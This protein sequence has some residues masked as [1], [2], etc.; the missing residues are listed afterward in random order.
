MLAGI[1]REKKK[2]LFMKSQANEEI[3]RLEEKAR[4]LGRT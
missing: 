2:N 3:K 1:L 4:L